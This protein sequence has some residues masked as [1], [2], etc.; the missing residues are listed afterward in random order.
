MRFHPDMMGTPYIKSA[1]E[2]WLKSENPSD[3]D[4]IRLKEGELDV[5]ITWH[6]EDQTQY[7]FWTSMPPEIRT[8]KKNYI[9]GSLL[10]KGKQLRSSEFTGTKCVILADVGSIAL[11]HVEKRDYTNRV[12]NGQQIIEAYLGSPECELDVVA[13]ITPNRMR[14]IWSSLQ[15][16]IDWKTVLFCKPGLQIDPSGFEAM[17]KALPKPRREGY[18]ARQLHEQNAFAPQN[19]GQY[20]GTNVT[21]EKGVKSEVR[22]S[23]RAL[24]DTL[25]GRETPEQFMR[26][27]SIRDNNNIFKS[28]LDRGETISSIRLEPGS[29]DDDDDSIV[30][31]FRDDPAARPLESPIQPE[32]DTNAN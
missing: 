29:A 27:L 28:H 20:L 7:N 30:V 15:E 10:R 24:L 9:Y 17:E 26:M 2:H 18:Q 3:G 16:T 19:R 14:E 11:R 6:N 4:K 21:W 23:A 8:L 25:A 31:E 13:V 1:L 22:F 12:I 5:V 32:K